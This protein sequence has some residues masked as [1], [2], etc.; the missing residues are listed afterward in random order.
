MLKLIFVLIWISI[1]VFALVA[2]HYR[3]PYKLIMVFGKK[4]SG[5]TT[6]ITKLTHKYLK[7]GFQVY[8]TAPVPGAYLFDAEDMGFINFPESV[9]FIDEVGMIWDNREFKKFKNEVRD[10]FKLQRHYKHIVYLFSQSFDIDVKLRNLTDTMYITKNIGNVI[11]FAR[12]VDRS[13]TIVHPNAQGEARIADDYNFTPIILFFLSP[14]Y[15]TWIP[16]W[17]KYFDS[18]E[19]P[20][21][22]NKDFVMCEYPEDFEERTLKF[23]IYNFFYQRFD[24]IRTR[25][26][27]LWI[28]WMNRD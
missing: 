18:F 19:A 9:I 5:K 26:A 20:E 8:S 10:Y 14:F 1:F 24:R 3:N 11:S 25:A 6:L 15:L 22:G 28:K 12:R 21:L 23:K 2:R 7:K 27:L 16:S 17:V 13:I 4:G